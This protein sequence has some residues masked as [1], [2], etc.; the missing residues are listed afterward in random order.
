MKISDETKA[1]LLDGNNLGKYELRS[2]ERRD[3]RNT[4]RDDYNRK[5][6]ARNNERGEHRNPHRTNNQRKHHS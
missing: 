4:S 3:R 6:D 2:A 5:H 1:R